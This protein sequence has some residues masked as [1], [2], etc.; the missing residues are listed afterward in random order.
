MRLIRDVECIDI[1]SIPSVD[2]DAMAIA[3]NLVEAGMQF[4]V[5]GAYFDGPPY[6]PE[7]TIL[8]D[9]ATKDPHELERPEGI[10][11]GLEALYSFYIDDPASYYSLVYRH[12]NMMRVIRD[13]KYTLVQSDLVRTTK[14]D[15]L[16]GFSMSFVEAISIMQMGVTTETYILIQ[17]IIEIVEDI[18]G[19][20][21]AEP[22]IA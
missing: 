10:G 13:Y 12:S 22:N 3:I 16:L 2:T 19:E 18:R 6:P 7:P 1:N 4:K 20:L 9:S 17:E 15:P 5:M 8:T 21:I 11:R 14:G